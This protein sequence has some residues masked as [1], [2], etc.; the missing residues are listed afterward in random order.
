MKKLISLCLIL[1]SIAEIFASNLAFASE[2]PVKSNSGVA[3]GGTKKP[4]EIAREKRLLEKLTSAESAK[5]EVKKNK[6]PKEKPVSAVAYEEVTLIAT[7]YYSP[8]P[9]QKYYLRNNHREELLLNGN[10]T[11]GASGKAVFN[12]MLA[13]PKGYGFGTKIWVEGFGIGSVEDRGGAIVPAGARGNEH[14]RIDI[15]M[16]YGEEGLARALAWGRR[17]VRAR[18]YVSNDVAVTFDFTKVKPA[19]LSKS[20]AKAAKTTPISLSIATATDIPVKSATKTAPDQVAKPDELDVKMKAFEQERLRVQKI[21]DELG[22]P[23]IGDVGPQ[24]R[25]LQE[26]LIE[27]GYLKSKSTA[28][29]GPETKKA[30]ANFQ[31][32]EGLILQM[33]DPHAG[34]LGKVTRAKLVDKILYQGIEV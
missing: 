14:D 33:D 32:S 19:N 21:I 34:V 23:K 2:T 8:L 20:I 24:I 13:A 5:T 15:W 25:M 12:G 4:L 10:G 11:H 18:I 17:S 22:A 31:K 27:M 16:G 7:A 30:V 26:I 9:D 3:I 6:T 29:Y 28:I 1:L